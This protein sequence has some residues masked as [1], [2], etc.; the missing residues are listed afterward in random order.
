M[1]RNAAT[2]RL[3]VGLTHAMP[4]ARVS[5]RYVDELAAT[6]ALDA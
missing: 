5:V 2:S 3:T 4:G 1:E 6:V